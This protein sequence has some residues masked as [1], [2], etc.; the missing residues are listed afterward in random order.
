MG[1]FSDRSYDKYVGVSWTNSAPEKSGPISR[2]ATLIKDERER[3]IREEGWDAK[4]DDKHK[5]SELISAAICYADCA[6]DKSGFHCSRF[7]SN[8][9]WDEKSWKP[10]GDSIKDLTKAGALIAAEIDRLLRK[11]KKKG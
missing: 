4:H 1:D 8:W 7:P 11:G 3:Q 5:L 6:R 2:G 10:T 9:P